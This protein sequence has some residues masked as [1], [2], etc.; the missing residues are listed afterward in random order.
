MNDERRVN[1]IHGILVEDSRVPELIKKV[2]EATP[3]VVVDSLPLENIKTNAIYAVKKYDYYSSIYGYKL[4]LIRTI[5]LIDFN[6]IVGKLIANGWLEEEIQYLDFGLTNGLL[7]CA[8][9]LTSE[10]VTVTTVNNVINGKLQ[11]SST[12]VYP[13]TE[14]NIEKK[15]N[16][17]DDLYTYLFSEN[18]ISDLV[19]LQI[20]TEEDIEYG[21]TTFRELQNLL[22][23]HNFVWSEIPLPDYQMGVVL[24][25]TYEYYIYNGQEWKSVDNIELVDKLPSSGEAGKVYAVKTGTQQQYRIHFYGKLFEP[26]SGENIES[27]SEAVTS[28][29]SEDVV[30]KFVFGGLTGF[31]PAQS[32]IENDGTTIECISN[33]YT[34]GKFTLSNSNNSNFAKP[35]A[36]YPKEFS[37]MAE[38]QE[39]LFSEQ[40]TKDIIDFTDIGLTSSDIQEIYKAIGFRYGTDITDD[41]FGV[42]FNEVSIYAYYM[43]TGEKWINLD[44]GDKS[45]IT[46]NVDWNNGNLIPQLEALTFTTA[47]FD[48]LKNNAGLEIICNMSNKP[49]FTMYATRTLL[50]DSDV[51]NGLEYEITV[52]GA[53]STKRCRMTI[54]NKDGKIDVDII[55]PTNVTSSY[56]TIPVSAWTEGGVDVYKYSAFTNVGDVETQSRVLVM[57]GKNDAEGGNFSPYVDTVD[58]GLTI[59]AKEKPTSAVSIHVEVF[60]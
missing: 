1:K 43:Y 6:T 49:F 21:K 57:F 16:T 37:T 34:N 25:V 40:F 27:F 60:N 22:R 18:W 8:S 24:D 32:I 31:L 44:A 2:D 15:F 51:A 23:S 36:Q 3:T 5:E 13:G 53:F 14:K 28:K 35:E 30:L 38:L 47:E 17:I 54:I 12:A 50:T 20:G 48:S 11:Y 26:I 10:E 33:L 29:F 7:P 55:E 46:K 19:T 9:T 56:T 45:V 58:G 41:E 42:S 59:Y 39:Y 52:V 4:P